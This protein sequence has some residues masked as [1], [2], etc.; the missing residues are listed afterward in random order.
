MIIWPRHRFELHAKFLFRNKFPIYEMEYECSEETLDIL[1]EILQ[2]HLK[3]IDHLG[4]H[5]KKVIPRER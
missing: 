1:A 4:S 3:L 2:L 5:C